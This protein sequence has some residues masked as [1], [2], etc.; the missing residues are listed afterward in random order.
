MRTSIRDWSEED[1]EDEKR[2]GRPAQP[3]PAQ[4]IAHISRRTRQGGG[5]P[6]MDLGFPYDVDGN[7]RDAAIPYLTYM[8][9]MWDSIA[10]RDAGASR[11]ETNSVA[12]I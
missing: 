5:S 7:L 4:A 1:S 8:Q 3:N 9:N 10:K 12:G 11:G 6:P 2:G